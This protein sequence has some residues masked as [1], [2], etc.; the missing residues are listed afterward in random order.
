MIDHIQGVGYYLSGVGNSS[1]SFTTF[2]IELSLDNSTLSWQ[3]NAVIFTCETTSSTPCEL[4]VISEQ[5]YE[6]D[7]TSGSCWQTIIG[8]EGGSSYEA[9]NW[10]WKVGTKSKN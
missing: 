7:N 9:C 1:G 4:D 2:S 3:D 8:G 6:C 10:P 5:T